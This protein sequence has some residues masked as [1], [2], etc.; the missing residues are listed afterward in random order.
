MGVGT[1]ESIEERIDRLRYWGLLIGAVLMAVEVAVV[2]PL[3]HSFWGG[4]PGLL[5]S[6]VLGLVIVVRARRESKQYW[7]WLAAT[8][9]VGAALYFEVLHKNR[10][11]WACW[12]LSAFSHS[13]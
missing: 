6:L 7:G 10:T 12:I 1:L 3:L 4:L 2:D 8:L 5:A 9:L 11:R 13:S